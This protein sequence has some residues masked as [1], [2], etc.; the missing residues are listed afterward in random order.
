M[1]KA[2][3]RQN[4]NFS[5]V[6]DQKLAKG[7][8]KQCVQN[9]LK[10]ARK[11]VNEITICSLNPFDFVSAP[12]DINEFRCH[13]GFVCVDKQQVCDEHHQCIDGSDDYKSGKFYFAISYNSCCQN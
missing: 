5:G 8:L 4:T 1:L 12:C 11:S 2:H 3:I 10:C 13:T 9:T 6:N 7:L